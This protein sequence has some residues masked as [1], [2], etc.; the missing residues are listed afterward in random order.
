M[1]GG[2]L[3]LVSL[4]NQNIILNGNPSK[5]MFKCKYA[6][7]TNFG[8]QKFRIDFDVL[9]IIFRHHCIL[10]PDLQNRPE[11]SSL[12]RKLV[13]HWSTTIWSFAFCI[14]STVL[15][16][17]VKIFIAICIKNIWFSTQKVIC[18]P[19]SMIFHPKCELRYFK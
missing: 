18:S 8:L 19:K 2:L 12:E 7:Y 14:F 6:K 15:D 10:Y 5:T 17:K 11:H 16:Q 3:N 13:L 1:P 4:G 9:V